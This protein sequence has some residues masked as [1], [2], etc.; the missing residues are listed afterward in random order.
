MGLLKQMQ[1]KV[2]EMKPEVKLLFFFPLN[3]TA[4]GVVQ[5]SEPCCWCCN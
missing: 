1:D 3:R 4:E 2:T 5:V